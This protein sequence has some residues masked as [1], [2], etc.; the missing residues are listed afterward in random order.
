ME[1]LTLKAQKREQVGKGASKNYRSEELVPGVLY[2]A[3]R[4][5]IHV[6]LPERILTNMLKTSGEHSLIQLEI[7]G[8]KP[9][10]SVVAEVQ[11]HP[12]NDRILH[13]DFKA[14][15]R[16]QLIEL[17]VPIEFVGESKGV[18][19]GGLFMA[20]VH[21]V[22]VRATPMNIP[23]SIEVDITDLTDEKALHIRDILVGENVE[24]IDDP[25]MSVA[26]ILKPKT[27]VEG[28]EAGSAVEASEKTEAQEEA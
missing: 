25:D 4:E 26:V 8:E 17:P 15:K 14:V 11:H 22:N 2:G 19:E 20:N 24:I 3:E 18:A 23:T 28:E 12:V 21:Q 7:E 9:Q 16:G 6:L 10:L 27:H 5:A 13:I 1:I